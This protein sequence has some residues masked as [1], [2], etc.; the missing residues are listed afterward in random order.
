MAERFNRRSFLRKLIALSPV[1]CFPVSLS[2]A[3]NRNI[4]RQSSLFMGTV[5][6]IDLANV[7]RDQSD[8]YFAK[9]FELGKNLTKIFNR[10]DS[11]SQVSYLNNTGKLEDASIHIIN[12]L[13]KSIE[14]NSLTNKS[15]D[16][17]ILPLVE[18][19]QKDKVSSKEIS[20]ILE[21]IGTNLVDINNKKVL[22]KRQGVQITFD[23]IAKG[24]IADLMSKALI[25]LG[26][27]NHLINAGGDIVAKGYKDTGLFWKIAIQDPNGKH[28]YP[29]IIDL[30]DQSIAT[31]AQYINQSHLVNALKCKKSSMYST[32]IIAP[33]CME[34]DAWATACS[35]MD[36]KS[37]LNISEINKNYASFMIDEKNNIFSSNNWKML[38]NN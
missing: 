5:V 4:F 23:G 10:F 33:T 29:Q 9:V 1:M 19:L 34:A 6:T 12:V 15:F 32:S 2:F 8:E 21:Y 14:L 18:L 22:F 35:V 38:V 17:T 11:D 36:I 37:S 7:S 28:N 25:E 31:S 16:V 13:K 24:Y 27:K 30:K 26:C 3:S 20:E